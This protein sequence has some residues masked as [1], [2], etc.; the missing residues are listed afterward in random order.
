[1]ALTIVLSACSTTQLAKQNWQLSSAQGLKIGQMQN[2]IKKILGSPYKIVQSIDNDE[3][4]WFYTEKNR[5]RLSLTFGI[6]DKRLGSINWHVKE[7]DNESNFEYAKKQLG[8][9]PYKITEEP[10]TNPHFGPDRIYYYDEKLGV[11]IEVSKSKQLV[12]N[13]SWLTPGPLQADNDSREPAKY[14][15]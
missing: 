8:N 14:E 9:G 4:Y 5:Q 12:Q 3:E 11:Q 10:W 1:M 7:S 2:E 6:S 13:I 15:F